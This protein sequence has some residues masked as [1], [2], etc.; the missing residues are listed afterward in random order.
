MKALRLGSACL[1]FSLGVSAGCGEPPIFQATTVVHADGTC[2]RTIRQPQRGFLPDD[3]RPPGAPDETDQI[4]PGWIA[5]WQKVMGAKRP[6]ASVVDRAPLDSHPYFEA[7]GIFAAPTDIPL[8]YYYCNKHNPAAGA[9]QLERQ[10]ERTDFGLL[11][12]YR[13]KESIT[14]NVTREQ[15]LA[16]VNKLLDYVLPPFASGLPLALG[17]QYE[18]KPLA[19]FISG[20]GRA[21]LVELASSFYDAR[22][23]RL[24]DTETS[25]RLIGVLNRAGFTWVPCDKPIDNLWE[26]VLKK[27]LQRR[28][29]KPLS[30]DDLPEINRQLNEFDW[31]NRFKTVAGQPATAPSKDESDRLLAAAL[32]PYPLSLI[33]NRTSQFDFALTLPG[34]LIETNGLIVGSAQTVWRFTDADTFPLGYAMRARSIVFK[35]GVQE[36]LLGRRAVDGLSAAAEFIELVGHD[37]PRLKAVQQAFAEESLA[38]IGG[39]SSKIRHEQ[40]S[41][42]RLQKL[43]QP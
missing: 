13:W 10:Y 21:E 20:A 9:S 35:S 7:N 34:A 19:D 31:D 6:P 38:P 41:I 43:L 8:H 16:G 25:A 11:V 33:F 3:A 1:L 39:L 17:E 5:R 14:N 24:G 23:H 28:D 37:G 40:Q 27:F 29:G 15:F 4:A 30:A 12:E 36:K 2:E 22:L 32:G 26:Q 18:T 42:E